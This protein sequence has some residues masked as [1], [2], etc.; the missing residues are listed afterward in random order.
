M[1]YSTVDVRLDGGI[2]TVLLN[3]PDR[4]NA[5]NRTL[6]DELRSAM[7]AVD[8]MPSVR[9]VILTGSGK[10]FCAGIDLEML[11]EMKG[12]ITS[13]GD[14]GRGA[15]QLRHFILDLQDVFNR[16]EKCRKPVIAAISGA[17]IGAGVDLATACDL[18]YAT[19][20]ARLCLKEIDMA[21]VADI[22]AVQRLPRLIGDGRS[23]EMIYTGRDV[24]GGEAESIGLVNKAFESAD[25]LHVA[26]ASIARAL[27]AKSPLTLRGCK[28]SV[29]YSRDHAVSDSLEQVAL[30][31]AGMMMSD[32]LIEAI[33]AQRDKR[34]PI[35]RD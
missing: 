19:A 16:V 34:A 33:D 27:A 14:R 12:I 13:G 1:T 2:A 18:R 10:H 6:W 11:T 8:A 7:T 15:D 24:S 17:C 23:R 25:A 29:L 32:D 31:N 5:L 3:R 26:V 4:A 35:F 22:G 30:W 9:V 20:D 21:I 28:Q